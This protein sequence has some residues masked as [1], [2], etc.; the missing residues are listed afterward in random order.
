MNFD[1][2]ITQA[3]IERVLLSWESADR[4]RDWYREQLSY[5]RRLVRG[6]FAASRGWRV[7]KDWF[8][9]GQLRTGSPRR[10]RDDYSQS[11]PWPLW[12]HP[13]FFVD[14]QNRP[15]GSVC[16]VYDSWRDTLRDAAAL[17]LK[18]ERLPWSWYRPGSSKAVLL[19]RETA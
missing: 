18:A 10:T 17:Q 8:S 5:M 19:T 1:S 3:E 14:A 15:V 7:A 2:P 9:I 6:A 16:H 12:K 11:V 13:S 4:N